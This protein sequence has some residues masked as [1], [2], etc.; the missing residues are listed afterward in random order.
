MTTQG[1][2]SIAYSPG[3]EIQITEDETEN[4]DTFTALQLA[5]ASGK[6]ARVAELLA[7]HANPNEAARGWYG[8]TA[9]QAASLHGHLSVV[10][11]LLSSGAMVDA[12]GGNNGGLNALTLAAG[13][14][15]LE[16]GERLLYAGAD[17]N[18][19]ADR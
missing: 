9:L 14:G 5:S 18:F 17:V 7:A 4:E 10:E 19:P 1:V 15:H 3:A 8:K 13:F 11:I 16:I 12:P 6:I 2:N